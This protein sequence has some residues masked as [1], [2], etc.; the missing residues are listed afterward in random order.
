MFLSLGCQ[1]IPKTRSFRPHTDSGLVPALIEV[2]GGVSDSRTPRLT[3][4]ASGHSMCRP[5]LERSN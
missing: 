3:V 1:H 4:V 2:F 5:P